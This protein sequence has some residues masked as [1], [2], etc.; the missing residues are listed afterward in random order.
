[1]T[2]SRREAVQVTIRATRPFATVP[3]LA[4]LGVRAVAGVETVE[5]RLYRRV[6]LSGG[7]AAVLTV[8]LSTT[9]SDGT[10]RAS[11]TPQLGYAPKSLISLVT[12]LVDADAPAERASY[13][14]E[15]DPLLAPMVRSTPGLRIPGTVSPFEL[16]VRAILGQQVSVAAASTFAAKLARA[17]GQTLS[18]PSEGLYRAFPSPDRLANAPIESVGVPKGRAAAIR[19]LA[20]LVVAGNIGAHRGG[21]DIAGVTEAELLE[22]PGI[23]PWTASYVGLRGLGNRDAIPISDLG[24]R[25]A[26]GDENPWSARQVAERAERWRP[27]RG[28]AAAHLWSTYLPISF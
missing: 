19:H 4:Y 25:Q 12:K 7:E 2:E 5:Q 1:M 8:D 11:C 23:G 9:E 26:L 6:I 10:I 18:W 14:L 13:A 17:W 16:A 21:E 27:W 15:E 28:Y 22:I 20:R 24:L 3:L